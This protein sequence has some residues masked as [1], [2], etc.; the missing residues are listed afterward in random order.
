MAFTLLSLEGEHQML[1]RY[2]ILTILLVLVAAIVAGC[3]PAETPPAPDVHATVN[4]APEPA[5]AAPDLSGAI[6]HTQAYA[7]FRGIARVA[8]G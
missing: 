6:A 4:T 1:S 5:A 2:V 3:N 8:G 7:F